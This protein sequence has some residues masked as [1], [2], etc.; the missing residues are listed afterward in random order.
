MKRGNGWKGCLL[1]YIAR[2][3]VVNDRLLCAR[4][5]SGEVRETILPFPTFYTVTHRLLT[6][7]PEG[8]E[9]WQ[10]CLYPGNTQH[11]SWVLSVTAG[12]DP[13]YSTAFT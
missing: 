10:R 1:K 5:S 6:L 7:D 13:A 3:D 12:Q 4:P 8:A 2:A 11:I 9:C